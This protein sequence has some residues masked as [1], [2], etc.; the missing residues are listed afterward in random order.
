MVQPGRRT[1]NSDLK[2]TYS[3]VRV[4]VAG[5]G[6]AG[7]GRGEWVDT[8]ERFVGMFMGD[9]SKSAINTSFTTG[10]VV[11]VAASIFEPGLTPKVVES[12]AWGADSTQ[13]I[14][15]AVATARIVCGRRGV[16]FTEVDEALLRHVWS[17]TVG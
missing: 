5:A 3:P 16:D 14:D 13:R 1:S 10:A 6:D 11:G 12:F 7:G 17:Q 15:D 2:N 4:W 9:H 8:G